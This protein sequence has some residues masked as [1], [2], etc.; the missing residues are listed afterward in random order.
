MGESRECH[1]QRKRN[2]VLDSSSFSISKS[3]CAYQI[4]WQKV[5]Q[6]YYNQDEEEEQVFCFID[7]KST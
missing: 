1:K 7:V 5:F 3:I 2:F 6:L 4:M